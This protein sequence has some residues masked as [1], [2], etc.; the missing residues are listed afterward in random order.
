MKVYLFSDNPYLQE[1]SGFSGGFKIP[2]EFRKSK[3]KKKGLFSDTEQEEE[4]EGPG[5]S[6]ITKD[7]ILQ[8]LNLGTSESG[9][10]VGKHG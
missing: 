2:D 4:V 5:Q 8:Q 7:E 10:G 9:I 1:R 6:H 3:I